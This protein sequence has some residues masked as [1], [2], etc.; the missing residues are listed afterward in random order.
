MLIGYCWNQNCKREIHADHL[1]Q[2]P[3][4]ESSGFSPDKTG[5]WICNFC[6]RKPGLLSAVR[7]VMEKKF[8]MAFPLPASFIEDKGLID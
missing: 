8:N 2:Y 7:K 3:K 4:L 6:R 1:H 5:P